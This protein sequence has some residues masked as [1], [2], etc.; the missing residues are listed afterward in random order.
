MTLVVALVV[1][2]AAVT[3]ASWNALT[4][5][6]KDELAA[7]TLVGTGR[8]ACGLVLVLFAPLPPVGAWPYLGASVLVHIGYQLVLIRSFRLGDFGKMYPIAR[9]TGPIVVTVFA[10][11]FLNERLHGW[12]ALGAALA[13]AGLV[14][15]A[16]WGVRGESA[17]PHGWAVAAAVTTGLAIAAY[18]VVD[19][20]GVR[21]CGP[22][23]GFLGY[24]GWLM[25]LDG[26]SIPGWAL[27]MRRGGLVG[28]IRPS[29]ARGWAGGCLSV[30]AYG[31]VLWSQTRAQLA[32]VALL[33]ESSILV[34]AIIA[35]VFFKEPFGGPRLVAAGLMLVGIMLMLGVR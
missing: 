2:L 18:T 35:K 8:A 13:A 30:V 14:G 19:G 11:L 21:A 25:L 28:R 1:L 22:G 4:H 32:P 16:L 10:M 34:G 31:L 23:D 5:S 15:L 6:I 9:G 20:V 29:L 27:V 33:R 24:V 26:A 12:S 3:H 17:R 7:L